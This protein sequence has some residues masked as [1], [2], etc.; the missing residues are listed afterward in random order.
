MNQFTT[1]SSN[2]E[3]T[4]FAV[5]KF[6][7]N[8]ATNQSVINIVSSNDRPYLLKNSL[9]QCVAAVTQSVLY[10]PALTINVPYI[11]TAF[12]RVLRG[13]VI[14]LGNSNR[15]IIETTFVNQRI[16]GISTRLTI[17][18]Y[19]ATPNSNN[20]PFEGYIHEFAAFRY[21]LTDQAIYQIEGYL[22]WKWGL[23]LS[24][25]TTHPYYK[26]RP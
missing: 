8:P 23:Q 25:P 21:A 14:V 6:T 4:N 7:I 22:A 9:V 12:R 26:I 5:V 3:Y 19:S 1:I 20:N 11:I 10:S 13:G 2:S 24:L 17:G 18:G 16:S 15:I